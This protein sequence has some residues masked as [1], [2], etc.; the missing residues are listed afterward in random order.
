MRKEQDMNLI[1]VEHL[2]RDYG[3]TLFTPD[4]LASGEFCA[5][6]KSVVLLTGAVILYAAGI[7]IFRKKDLCI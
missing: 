2:T 3:F 5:I 1:R 6:L 4:Q 7:L